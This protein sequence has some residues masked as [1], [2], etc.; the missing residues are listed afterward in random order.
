MAGFDPD[1]TDVDEVASMLKKGLD[2]GGTAHE[3]SVE[4]QGDH[5]VRV[6]EIL[7]EEGV[8]VVD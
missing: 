7:E 6:R 3:T 5:A 4:V 8:Q 1:V 2:A